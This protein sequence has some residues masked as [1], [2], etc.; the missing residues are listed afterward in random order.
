MQQISRFPLYPLQHPLVLPTTESPNSH[1]EKTSSSSSLLYTLVSPLDSVSPSLLS[2]TAPKSPTPNKSLVSV[3]LLSTLSLGLS[4]SCSTSYSGV[5][6]SVSP[7]LSATAP[8][9]P[10]PNKSSSHSIAPLVALPRSVVAPVLHIF[11]PRL[12]SS[13]LSHRALIQSPLRPL[14]SLI[15]LSF[16][17]RALCFIDL[18][19]PIGCQPLVKVLVFLFPVMSVQRWTQR[20]I[21]GV[22]GVALVSPLVIEEN[23]AFHFKTH[24]TMETEVYE[25]EFVILCVGRFGGLPKLPDFPINQGPEVFNGVVTLERICSGR[26]LALYLVREIARKEPCEY[27]LSLGCCPRDGESEVLQSCVIVI[28]WSP[29]CSSYFDQSCWSFGDWSC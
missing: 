19:G 16:S 12:C 9:S 23:G 6:L 27:A 17:P 11:S 26:Y 2:S 3:P 20:W 8:K 25:V 24:L 5:S 21:H 22:Y 4:V 15:V 13:R 10:T 14:C 18:W 1:R 29:Y 7:S 28:I